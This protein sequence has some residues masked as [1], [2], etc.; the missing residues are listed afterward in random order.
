MNNERSLARRLAFLMI[1]AQDLGKGPQEEA[2]RCFLAPDALQS[3]LID[4]A[5]FDDEAEAEAAAER[6]ERVMAMRA[7]TLA[8]AEAS[9]GETLF[10]R[11]EKAERILDY[12]EATVPA[13]VGDFGRLDALIDR[14]SKKDWRAERLMSADRNILRLAVYE[15]CFAPEAIDAPVIINEAVELAKLYGEDR[16]SAFVNALLDRLAKEE[17]S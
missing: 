10:A 13:V 7:G 15:L 5:F 16:S 8:V 6:I 4:A 14:Y 11:D 1:Y 2:L 17:R 3:L 9:D 12:L